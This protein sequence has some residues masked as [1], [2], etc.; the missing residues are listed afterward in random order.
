MERV[1]LMGRLRHLVA[2][3]LLLAPSLA[4]ACPSCVA[5]DRNTTVL[6]VVGAFMLV[7][8]GIF[9]FVLRTVRRAA[10][11]VQPSSDR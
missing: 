7:P 2:L 4:W 10:R 11:D 9:F 3:A 6:K 5:Q 8:F 1:R